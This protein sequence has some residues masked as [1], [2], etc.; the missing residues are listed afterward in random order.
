MASF[1]WNSINY[2]DTIEDNVKLEMLKIMSTI[3]ELFHPA[4]FLRHFVYPYVVDGYKNGKATLNGEQIKAFDCITIETSNLVPPGRSQGLADEPTAIKR[5][6]LSYKTNIK[7]FPVKRNGQ[8]DW[9]QMQGFLNKWRDL[10]LEEI[11]KI[12]EEAN[13]LKR[14]EEKKRLRKLNVEARE[15]IFDKVK[16]SALSYGVIETEL[17]SDFMNIK[18]KNN[19]K[20]KISAEHDKICLSEIEIPAIFTPNQM[21]DLEALL[22]QI[23]QLKVG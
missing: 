15:K 11:A 19:L 7:Y 3:P 8:F 18:L 22:I 9:H 2:I 1:T 16:E 5:L 6:Q 14:L 13:F 10:H 23:S 12:E 17:P 4:D 21:G 20:V